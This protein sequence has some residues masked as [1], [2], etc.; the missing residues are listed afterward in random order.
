MDKEKVAFLLLRIGLSF[1]FLYAAFSSFLAPSNWIGYFP[2]FI[3]NLVTENILLPLFS[4]FEITLALWILWGKYLFYSSVLASISLLGII[5]FNF[6][7]MDIIFRDV[8]ILLMAISLVV[9]SYNDKLK[10]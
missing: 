3:R 6:N 2:V 4:I 7:Q 1:A 5:I 9:Y 8:S 10:L